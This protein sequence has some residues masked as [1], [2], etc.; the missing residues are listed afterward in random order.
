MKNTFG[1]K[2]AVTLFGESHGEVIGAVLDGMPS[3]IAV[4]FEF[5]SHRLTQ[6]RGA[7]SVSTSRRENDDF[8]FVSGILNGVTTGA[9]ICVLIKNENAVSSDYDNL[10]YTPR[11]SHSDYTLYKKYG[12]YNDCRGGGHSS[13]RL[14]APLVA[15][16]AICETALKEKGIHILTHIK[17]CKDISDDDFT[18]FKSDKSALEGSD[19]PVL[20]KK[21]GESIKEIII[22]AKNNSDSLGAILETGIF[23]IDAG[24]G[25]PWFDTL[26]GVISHAVF[27]VPAVKGIEFGAGFSFSKMYGS[28]ANDEMEF[29]NG[30]VKF[31]SNNNGGILGG[32]SN[33]APIIFKTAIKPTPSIGKTQRT[34]NLKTGEN[35]QIEIAGRHDPFIAHK[36]SV[37]VTAVTAIALCGEI[38][39]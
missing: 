31:L 32:M 11:P 12:G 15:V 37:A 29:S 25:E 26:E 8:K 14:T 13:G 16:G 27:S 28:Q 3:G 34:V 38:L 30:K 4:D 23:G 19:F 35:V 20:N 6:R 7:Q 17:S 18:D 1:N 22:E 5:I 21:A 39:Q 24:Y 33:G 2:I 10:K 9:P 36:A